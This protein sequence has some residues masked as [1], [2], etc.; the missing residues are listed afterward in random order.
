MAATA[1]RSI[2]LRPQKANDREKIGHFEMDAMCGRKGRA[3]IQNKVDRKSRKMFLDLL[4]GLKSEE[5]AARY[6]QRFKGDIGS[7]IL[8]S[9]TLDNDSEHAEHVKLESGLGILVYFC[10]PYCA[11][12]RG[13]VEN[14]NR[15][16]RRFLSKGACLDDLLTEY[17]EWIEDYF[18][19]M[20]MKVLGYMT[21][22]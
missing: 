8:K 11:S 1:K 21:P 10:H 16:L 17:L 6:I 18:N 20:P 19:N 4:G 7:G 5:Y 14:R 13:T 15:A 2:E 12:E 22:N 3:V 9:L